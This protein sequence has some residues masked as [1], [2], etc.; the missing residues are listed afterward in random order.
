[1]KKINFYINHCFKLKCIVVAFL[2]LCNGILLF[3]F[4]S[5]SS[6][7]FEQSNYHQ[8]I[9]Q[10]INSLLES[11]AEK[12][13]FKILQ[14]SNTGEFYSYGHYLKKLNYYSKIFAIISEINSEQNIRYSSYLFTQA[15]TST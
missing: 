1:M 10:A 4:I 8:I 9:N 7:E 2:F 13:N 12:S 15:Q 5:L 6:F 11:S 14:D 3:P